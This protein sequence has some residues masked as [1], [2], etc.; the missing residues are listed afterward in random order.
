MALYLLDSDAVID[1]LNRFPPTLLLLRSLNDGGETLCT[2]DVVLA[3]VYAGLQ[4][5]GEKPAS[6]FLPTLR[7]LTSSA[8]A[9]EQAGRWRYAFNRQGRPLPLTDALIAAT[10]LTHRATI[11]TGNVRDFPMPEV[12]VLQLPR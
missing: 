8:V 9:A 2:C 11:V 5:A 4:P 7:F 1:Y 12:G 6:E 10:A 3:E